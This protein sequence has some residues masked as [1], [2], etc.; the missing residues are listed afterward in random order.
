MA[1]SLLALHLC[2]P[3]EIIVKTALQ[4]FTHD[5]PQQ[6]GNLNFQIFG[7]KRKNLLFNFNFRNGKLFRAVLRR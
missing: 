7:T 5:S 1:E 6:P 2:D 3:D 4:V